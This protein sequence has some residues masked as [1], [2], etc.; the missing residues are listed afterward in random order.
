MI[1]LSNIL[2]KISTFHLNI[3]FLLGL[4]LFGG[5][6]GGRIFQKL[7]IPQV[8]GY[9]AIGIIIGESGAR[10]VSRDI[11]LALQPF[12]YFALGLIGFMVGGELKK[13][14]FVKY[15]KQFMTILLCEGVT[16]FII[17]SLITG[18]VGT[19]LLGDW[20]IA[21]ALALLLGAISSATDPATS[22]E[23][24]REYKTRGPLTQA[25]LSI[26]ALDD[27]LAIL[28]FVIASSVAGSL[29]GN[30]HSG[31]LKSLI[32]PIYEIGGSIIVGAITGL[33]FSKIISRYSEKGRLL[34][35]S[36]GTVLLV[37]GLSLA[38]K[39]ELLLTAMTAGV[40]VVNLAPRR[41]KDIFELIGGFT[42]PIYVLFFVFIGAKLNFQNLTLAT[43]I[44]VI[45]Y[46]FGT[47]FGKAAGARLGAVISGAPESVKKYLPLGLFSQ[48][49]VAI[50]LSILATQ[51]FPGEIGNS[52]VVIITAT[53][54]ILQ[55]VGPY[56]VKVAVTRAGEVGL[57]ITEEDIIE[58]SKA[59][60][61][62]DKNTP[63]I[64]KATPLS[65][66]LEIFSKSPNLYYPVIDQEK[67]LL[68]IITVD[69]IKNIFNETSLSSFLLA[70]DLMEPV[71]AKVRPE[72]PM[73]EV[74][75]LLD[76]H[77][78]ECL[79]V[80]GED[81]KLAGFIERRGLDK[82]ISTK[83]IE[84]REKSD[85]LEQKLNG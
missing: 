43:G 81:N 15:G 70:D 39:I 75:E 83:I 28:L 72:T 54:F 21:W 38:L 57:N 35:F 37:T 34:A 62:M 12:N 80:A 77:N 59:G 30:I 27:G 19:F 26:V 17:V 65:K 64:Y 41:S 53:T 56:F 22:T 60:E 40:V 78:L 14:V 10:V 16:P 66:I 18:V 3:L 73:K 49:G 6:V 76:R 46:I 7:R 4:A 51:Y 61:L 11:I 84:L 20:R 29:S 24:L 69:N 55:L 58:A 48:A 33:V 32:N 31:L 68:G 63:V 9:I 74:Q 36:I 50:G 25:I 8:V 1:I 23:V 2:S 45:I 79:P 44:L 13:E 82:A 5:T 42:P 67:N 52:L 47:M 85:S 71:I